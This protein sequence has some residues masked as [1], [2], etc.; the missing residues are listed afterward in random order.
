LEAAINQFGEQFVDFYRDVN[1]KN[2]EAWRTVVG[3]ELWDTPR[4]VRLGL[5]LQF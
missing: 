4:Q 2:G 1:I 5:K 3:G